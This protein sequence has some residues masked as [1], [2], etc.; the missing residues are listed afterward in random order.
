[1]NGQKFD[2]GLAILLEQ[3]ARSIYDKRA[4]G[5]IHPGQ[6]STLRY[7]AQAGRK[8]RTVAGLASYLGVTRGPASR[9]ASALVNHGFLNSEKNT[10]DRRSPVFT[11]TSKGHSVLEDDPIKRLARVISKLEDSEQKVLV[12]S[13]NTIYASLNP[14]NDTEI[15]SQSAQGDD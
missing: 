3:T 13:L 10:A 2:I 14:T 12:E 7:F 4:P 9:A 1:M 15:E 8:A 5:D 11:L 6:W